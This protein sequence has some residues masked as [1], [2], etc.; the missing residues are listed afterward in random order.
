VV[1]VVIHPLLS[2]LPSSSC[3]LVQ[4]DD[5]NDGNDGRH[6]GEQ[7]AS[8]P[9]LQKWLCSLL[10]LLLLLLI[11]LRPHFCHCHHHLAGCSKMMM[12][13]TKM[14]CHK[15]NHR[16]VVASSCCGCGCE[17]HLLCADQVPIVPWFP[18]LLQ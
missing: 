10:L 14:P 8:H 9:I 15:G 11:H 3:W 2:T 18:L 5:G 6:D 1:C 13:M 12:A 7:P 16:R 4:D 17:S